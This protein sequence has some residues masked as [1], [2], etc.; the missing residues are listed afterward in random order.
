VREPEPIT[1][2][3]RMQ[4]VEASRRDVLRWGGL[5]VLALPL[6]ACNGGFDDS[7][8]PL[9]AL[10]A[11]ARADAATARRLGDDTATQVAVVRATQAKALQREVDR[12]NRPPAAARKAAAPKDLGAL[13]KRLRAEGER[14]AEL[15]PRAPR[16]RA[17]LLASVAAGCAG[18]Q[19]LDVALGKPRTVRFTEPELSGQ[20]EQG[21]LD[22]LQEALDAE[23]AALWILEQVSAFLPDG[24]DEGLRAADDEHRERRDVSQRVILSAG[25]TPTIAEAAYV[26]QK[27]VAN[28][29]TARAAVIA[30][31]S[32][33]TVAWRGVIERCDEP[34]LREFC[35]SAMSASAVRLTKWRLDAG[36]NPAAVALPGG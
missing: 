3:G 23:H 34:A 6:A 28:A 20:L 33:A 26:T 22:V 27:P 8:D 25:A 11:A 19:A 31:E 32:E 21:T 24:Y 1:R 30:A 10:A 15:L 2:R 7:P 36:L 12:A 4:N 17:G 16:Y 13:G 14:A 18:A 29:A 9:A 5:T 35:V